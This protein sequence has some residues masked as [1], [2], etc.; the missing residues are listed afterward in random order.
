[1]ARLTAMF[2]RPTPT[3]QTRCPSSARAAATIIISA[4]ENDASVIAE[5]R[6]G[7]GT[8]ERTNAAKPTIWPC[9]G[10][11]RYV[12]CTKPRELGHCQSREGSSL[13][14]WFV[15]RTKARW[16]ARSSVR[17]VVDRARRRGSGR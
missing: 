2:G 4:L 17:P 12:R 13:A 14:G 9:C 6:L 16:P 7:G 11:V 3:K 15:E 8:N 1:L 10:A 5:A